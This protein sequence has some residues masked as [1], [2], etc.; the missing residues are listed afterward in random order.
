[1]RGGASPPPLGVTLEQVT[2]KYHL[3]HAN[4]HAICGT[5]PPKGEVAT[6][7][8]QVWLMHTWRD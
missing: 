1:M 4:L 5:Q 3:A 6:P 8:T 2:H 7:A